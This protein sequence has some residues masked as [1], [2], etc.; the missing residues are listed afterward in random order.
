MSFHFP[1]DHNR[2]FKE[3]QPVTPSRD[4]SKDQKEPK[5]E[6]KKSTRTPPPDEKKGEQI[7]F[8]V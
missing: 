6:K 4:K 7:D 2:P 1:I 5:K 3:T 8:F